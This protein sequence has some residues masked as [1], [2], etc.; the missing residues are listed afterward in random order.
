MAAMGSNDAPSEVI[1]ANGVLAVADALAV[2]TLRYID[3][4]PSGTWRPRS[5][6]VHATEAC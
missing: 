3:D 2:L 1:A 5:C 4:L 6:T